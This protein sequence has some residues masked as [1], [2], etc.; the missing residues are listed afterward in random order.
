MDSDNSSSDRRAQF[1]EQLKALVECA[2]KEGQLS[3]GVD[4]RRVGMVFILDH[5]V[6]LST[7]LHYLQPL[8]LEA[9]VEL[10]NDA[11]TVIKLTQRIREDY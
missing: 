11:V 7:F 1:N 6:P 10:F 8:N 4:M 5:A 9:N 3:L 2:R